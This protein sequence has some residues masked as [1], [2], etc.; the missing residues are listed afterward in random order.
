MLESQDISSPFFDLSRGNMVSWRQNSGCSQGAGARGTAPALGRY[1]HD[2]GAERWTS[3]ATRCRSPGESARMTGLN[4]GGEVI[5]REW[6][7]V[8]LELRS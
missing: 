5:L 3:R 1:N 6:C 7:M 2:P 4:R 8:L